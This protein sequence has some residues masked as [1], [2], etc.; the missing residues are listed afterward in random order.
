MATAGSMQKAFRAGTD[1]CARIGRSDP[2]LGVHGRAWSRVCAEGQ[3]V[4][5]RFSRILP[6]ML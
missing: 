2:A 5:L 1:S 3:P 4:L 6:P